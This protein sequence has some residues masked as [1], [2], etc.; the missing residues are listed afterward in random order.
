MV[1]ARFAA[2]LLPRTG[3]RALVLAGCG[4]FLAGFGWLAQAGAGTGYVTGVLGPT[5]LVAVGIGLTFPT[6]MAAATADAPEGDAGVVGGLA[7]TASQA[8]GSA[9]LAILAT[10]AATET[11][12]SPPRATTW[13]SS[14][15][16]PWPWPSP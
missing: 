10:I 8:G 4:A 16:P 2:A 6:L 3:V 1:V 12:P 11:G 13:S 15:R 9:G 14:P 5:L 7:N